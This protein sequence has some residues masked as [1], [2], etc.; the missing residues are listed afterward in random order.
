MSSGGP[1]NHHPRV[2]ESGRLAPDVVELEPDP[3]AVARRG[4][5]AGGQLQE[6]ATEEVDDPGDHTAGPVLPVDAQAE[7]LL[8]EGPTAREVTDGEQDSTA[9]DF[10]PRSLAGL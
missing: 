4:A 1:P 2:D 3:H 8:V 6:S 7:G 10:H 5:L 9:E